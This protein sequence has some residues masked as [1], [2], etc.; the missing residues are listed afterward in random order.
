[1]S[2]LVLNPLTARDIWQEY[3]EARPNPGLEYEQWVQERAAHYGCEPKTVKKIVANELHALQLF[4]HK[5]RSTEAQRV[6][7]AAGLTLTKTFNVLH[8]MLD[9]KKTRREYYKGDLV[10]EWEETD[11]AAQNFAVRTA[12]SLFG[13]NAPQQVHHEIDYGEDLSR[14]TDADLKLRFMELMKEVG[15][16]AG[17]IIEA[18]AQPVAIGAGDGADAPGVTVPALAQRSVLLANKANKNKGRASGKK[19]RPVRKPAP[20]QLPR[21]GGE[22][23]SGSESV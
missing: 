16:G 4:T 18:T 17:D 12:M 8:R 21:G 20:V 2:A 15:L 23:G 11:N 9:A 22:T 6:A 19:R 14:A 7:H 13:A 1:M 10:D 5:A 3:T